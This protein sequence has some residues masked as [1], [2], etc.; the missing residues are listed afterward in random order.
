M[1]FKIDDT[2]IAWVRNDSIITS[3]TD[4]DISEVLEEYQ[5]DIIT[6]FNKKDSKNVL[7]SYQEWDYK[8]KLKLNTKLTKQPIYPLSLK[9]LEALQTYLNNNRRK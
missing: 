1:I 2:Y 7:P 4:N 6:L 8:I 3:K 9:K 5:E